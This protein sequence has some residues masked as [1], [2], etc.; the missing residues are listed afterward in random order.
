LCL[1]KIKNQAIE[2]LEIDNV[3][4]LVIRRLIERFKLV[5]HA[6]YLNIRG[7]FLPC[8]VP[9]TFCIAIPVFVGMTRGFGPRGFVYLKEVELHI[10]HDIDE[11]AP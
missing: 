7:V 11:L 1:W 5:T 6:H 10:P 2:I 9:E 4:V 3:W 8:Y